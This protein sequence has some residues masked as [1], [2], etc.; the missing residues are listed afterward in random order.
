M[1]LETWREPRGELE[2]RDSQRPDIRLFVIRSLLD[3]LWCQPVRRH[4][5]GAFLPR[6]LHEIPREEHVRQFR[7]TVRVQQN[8]CG[9]DVLVTSALRVEI[10]KAAK[11]VV[12]DRSDDGFGKRPALIHLVVEEV[13]EA[14]A[15]DVVH[16]DPQL[17]AFHERRD[18]RDEV[19]RIETQ[20]VTQ[21]VLDD[22]DFVVVRLHVDDFQRDDFP[23]A[24][25]D[26]LVDLAKGTLAN[27]LAHFVV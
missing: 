12:D 16:D 6:G 19:R 9:L 3:D 27:E 20:H 7:G 5:D 2:R 14:A 4:H 23:G 18:V 1:D 10:N 11:H 22:L 8:I 25:L 24:A 15:A 26:A 21:L 13:L 17:S